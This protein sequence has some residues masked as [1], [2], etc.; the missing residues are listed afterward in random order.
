MEFEKR[1]NMPV[2]YDRDLWEKTGNVYIHFLNVLAVKIFCHLTSELKSHFNYSSGSNEEG[3]RN[4]TE[5]TGEVYHEQVSKSFCFFSQA[6]LLSSC[7]LM[8]NSFYT[9]NLVLAMFV[10]H[11]LYLSPLYRLK[12]GKQLEREEAISEVKKNIHLIKAPHA[13]KNFLYLP[14]QPI[15]A[16]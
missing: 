15:Y 16:D 5:T 10:L 12:K 2:K 1:R 13:G 4:K 3:G 9:T 14:H 7:H 11:L 6:Y 8:F